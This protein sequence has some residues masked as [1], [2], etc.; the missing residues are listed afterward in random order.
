M[1]V[2]YITNQK[3]FSKK[4]FVEDVFDNFLVVEASFVTSHSILIEGNKSSDEETADEYVSWSEVK[5]EAFNVIKGT[6]LP[7]SFK[8]VL[9]LTSA[10]TESTLKNIGLENIP[11]TGLYLNIKYSDGQMNII[12]GTSTSSF[13]IGKELSNGWETLTQ[14]FLKKKE[15][16][17]EEM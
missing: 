13:E 16:E 6:K 10:N 17:F 12:T 1:K 11:G 3:D 7:K 9:K 4:L 15:I 8:I 5:D 2:F 14:K